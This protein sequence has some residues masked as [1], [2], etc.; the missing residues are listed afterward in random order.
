MLLPL[1]L[2]N[3]AI[4]KKIIQNSKNVILTK[5]DYNKAHRC[6][7]LDPY[8]GQQ[9]CPQQWDGLPVVQ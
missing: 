4:D 7:S 8:E 1:C 6:H 2:I 5:L 3:P 9:V